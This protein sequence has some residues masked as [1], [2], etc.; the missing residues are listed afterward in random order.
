MKIKKLYEF[1][2]PAKR[3]V[4]DASRFQ[5]FS[6][7]VCVAESYC[8]IAQSDNLFNQKYVGLFRLKTIKESRGKG[9]MRYLLDQ[10]FN[11]VKNDLKIDYILLNVYK[12][13]QKALNLYFKN[14]FEVYKDFDD[15]EDDEPYFT[16]I[17]KLI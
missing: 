1:L 6:E 13:N 2:E 5:L 11:Y 16:L 17:K 7:D 10:I 14:G 8:V 12:D 9:F 15:V 3:F 4:V